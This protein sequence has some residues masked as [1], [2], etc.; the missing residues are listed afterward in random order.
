M[1]AREGVA[2]VLRRARSHVRPPVRRELE[3]V[4]TEQHGERDED[5]VALEIFFLI[6]KICPPSRFA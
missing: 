3:Q 4:E 5:F 6:R 2:A 1:F